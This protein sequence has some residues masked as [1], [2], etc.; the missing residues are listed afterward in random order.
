MLRYQW[1]SKSAR[2]GIAQCRSCRSGVFAECVYTKLREMEGDL[3]EFYSRKR[4]I[5]L[6]LNMGAGAL[7]ISGC[8]LRSSAVFFSVQNR[9]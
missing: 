7:L 6:I 5:N 3:A 4:R 8:V 2:N 9:C 1:G